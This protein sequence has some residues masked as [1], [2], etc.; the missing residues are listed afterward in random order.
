MPESRKPTLRDVLIRP[1]IYAAINYALLG[2]L[3]IA[4]FALA[5]V[6]F[7]VSSDFI[8]DSVTLF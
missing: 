7:A 4:V 5:T 8:V 1:V 2:F 6:F 3:D